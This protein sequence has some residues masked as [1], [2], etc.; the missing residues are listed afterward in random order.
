MALIPKSP[1]ALLMSKATSDFNAFQQVKEKLCKEIWEIIHIEQ[2]S[3]KI[4][5][6]ECP[7]IIISIMQS[8]KSTNLNTNIMYGVSYLLCFQN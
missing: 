5:A 6:I 2:Q 4:N 1:K 8:K 3:I 7:Q